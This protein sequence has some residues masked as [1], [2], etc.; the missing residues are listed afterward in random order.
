[1][2]SREIRFEK[3]ADAHRIAS[4]RVSEILLPMGHKEGVRLV[5]RRARAVVSLSVK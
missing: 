2:R 3:I 5:E 1:M 4:K